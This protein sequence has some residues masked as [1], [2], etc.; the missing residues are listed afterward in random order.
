[1]AVAERVHAQECHPKMHTYILKLVY[2]VHTVNCYMFRPTLRPS[3][4]I[5][6]KILKGKAIPVQ[7]WTDPGVSR[8]FT[9][10]KFQDNRH[11]K[12]VRL[13]ALS[14]GRLYLPRKYSRYS[15][16]LEGESTLGPYC[17]RKEAVKNCSDTIG[18]QTR[19]FPACSSLPQRL[20]TLKV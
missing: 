17:F 7:G 18:N 13:S 4:G 12:V 19:D 6:I 10:A 14:T 16:L 9:A 2:V 15:F 5:K 3:P 11:V 20:D 1:M 8:S